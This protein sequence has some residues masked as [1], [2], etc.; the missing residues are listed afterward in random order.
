MT[1]ENIRLEKLL[2]LAGM[3]RVVDREVERLRA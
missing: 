2:P 1:I 3:D